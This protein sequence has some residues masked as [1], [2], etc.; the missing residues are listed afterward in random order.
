MTTFHAN[1]RFPFQLKTEVGSTISTLR[2]TGTVS[3]PVTTDYASAGAS[4]WIKVL[5]NGSVFAIPY[6]NPKQ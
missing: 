2:I 4:G 6:Y 3:T 1:S 5:V